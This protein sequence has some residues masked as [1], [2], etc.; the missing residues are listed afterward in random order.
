MAALAYSNYRPG[1]PESLDER[2]DSLVGLIPEWHAR[3]NCRGT[4][5]ETFFPEKGGSPRDAKRICA[6]CTV[7]DECRDTA[8]ANGEAF[9]VWGGLSNPERR[10]RARKRAA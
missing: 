6:R 9:G 7:Q 4:D 8:L 10:R 2:I 3:A 1:R 5:P